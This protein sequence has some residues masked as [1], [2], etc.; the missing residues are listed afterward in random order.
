[1]S[2]RR[3]KL[4]GKRWVLEFGALG[5]H[6]NEAGEPVDGLCYPPHAKQK[7]ILIDRRLKGRELLR[8]LLHELGHA[9][10]WTKCEDF[11]ELQSDDIATVLWDLGYRRQGETDGSD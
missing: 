1:M 6:R 10:D 3:I 9:T 2:K 7:R 5:R 11:I 4:Q 8:V